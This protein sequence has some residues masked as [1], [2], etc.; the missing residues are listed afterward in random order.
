MLKNWYMNTLDGVCKQKHTASAPTDG[1]RQLL[2]AFCETN[3]YSK[4][5]GRRSST[6]AAKL[7]PKPGSREAKP[8]SLPPI[9]SKTL[10][11]R[12]GCGERAECPCGG[13][14]HGSAAEGRSATQGAGWV[15]VGSEGGEEHEYERLT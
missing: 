15:R 11:Q 5:Q 4:P 12:R 2:A 7:P 1:L 10:T 9:I 14:Q 13:R 6:T 3:V 8:S